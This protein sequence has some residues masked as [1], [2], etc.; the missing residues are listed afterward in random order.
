MEL[1]KPLSPC[2]A[3]ATSPDIASKPR[4]RKR[5]IVCALLFFAV[6]LSYIDRLVISVLKP[7]LSAQYGWSETGYA[8]LALYFQL[9]YGLAYLVSG[10]IVDRIGARLGYM[11]AVVLWTFGHVLH[12]AFTTTSGMIWARLPLAAG[13]AATFPAALAAAAEWFPKRERAL[14]IGIFNAGSN[15]GAV[16]T[17]LL[18]PF[19]V[20]TLGLGWRA[21]FVVTGA[22]SLVWLAA[23]WRFYRSPADH[24][25]LTAEERDW[26]QAEKEAPPR[27][28]RWSTILR[29]RQS[30]AYILGRF[31]IDPIWWTFLFW[32]PDFFSR[33]FHLSLRE[34][35]PPLVAVYLLADIGSVGGGW[36]SSRLLSRGWTVNGARK[37]AM[38]LCALCAVP[39]AFATAAP[40]M[41]V[42]VGL[43]GL[44][45]AGHQGF[46]ANLYALPGDVFPRWM[47][48]SVVGLGGLAGATGGM[49]MAKFAGAI[50]QTVGSYQPI[51]LVAASA[52]LVALLVIHMVVPRYEPV[53]DRGLLL[54]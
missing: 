32:L 48:G 13:E 23:W 14:A 44:A 20:V 25:T 15:V 39:I 27:P 24:P 12:I 37:F 47:I 33:Q 49:L 6:V 8:D 42:A 53:S 9:V 40:S 50:L 52:Y 1:V 28:V 3:A 36:V 2:P 19:I 38:L 5:W 16:V 30:W 22:L 34:F 46:S 51:F 21:A 11:L 35:G 10:R 26:I 17:P 41:W 31:L 43:I 18:V 4:G 29:T 45:C 54:A 7:E